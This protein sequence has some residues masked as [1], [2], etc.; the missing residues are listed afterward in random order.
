MRYASEAVLKSIL[1]ENKIEKIEE[2]QNELEIIN[3]KASKI[4]DELQKLK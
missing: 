1:N 3:E 4:Y 2:L